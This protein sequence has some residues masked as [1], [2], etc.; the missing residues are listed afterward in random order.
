VTTIG[1]MNGPWAVMLRFVLASYPLLLIW[2]A[3]VTVNTVKDISFRGEGERFTRV[4]AEEQTLLL[5][6][7]L[8]DRLTVIEVKLNDMV[9]ATQLVTNAQLLDHERLGGHAVMNQRVAHLEK[10]VQGTAAV[11][12][13]ETEILRKMQQDI[14]SYIEWLKAKQ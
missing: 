14:A 8:G 9:P 1:N 10:V 4:D 13:E 5:Q 11:E 12:A 3:W 7:V 2:G 6:R